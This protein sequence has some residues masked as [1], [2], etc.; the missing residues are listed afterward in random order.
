MNPEWN[1]SPQST[2]RPHLDVKTRT[3]C[4]ADSLTPM[5]TPGPTS[6]PTQKSLQGTS[7]TPTVSAQETMAS[8]VES[9]LTAARS[10]N[11][12]RVRQALAVGPGPQ[13]QEGEHE[14]A[15]RAAGGGS[16]GHLKVLPVLS[17]VTLIF[18]CPG[19]SCC[20]TALEGSTSFSST[21]FSLSR[22]ILSLP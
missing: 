15:E 1:N 18:H 7:N 11:I 13:F 12:T 16:F 4:T 17:L 9:L 19:R 22:G 2:S 21:Y 5:L 8:A 3:S 10:N 6:A 14:A 20:R